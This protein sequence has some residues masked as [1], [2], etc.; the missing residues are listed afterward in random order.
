MRAA[1]MRTLRTLSALCA[2]VL[3]Q[4]V[5]ASAQNYMMPP[6]A[7]A[8]SCPPSPY[9]FHC[10]ISRMANPS[11]SSH[12]FYVVGDQSWLMK[13]DYHFGFFNEFVKLRLNNGADITAVVTDLRSGKR[14][15]CAE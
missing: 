2:S 3:S 11:Y 14:A 15:G 9:R 1:R 12:C 8:L 4:P 10:S 5:P 6:R 7:V 13:T